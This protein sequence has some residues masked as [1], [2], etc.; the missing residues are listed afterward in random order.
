MLHTYHPLHGALVGFALYYTG[1]TSMQTA[2]MV[3]GAAA[4]YMQSYGHSL[5]F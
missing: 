4:L 1:T 5:P 3:G 2:L